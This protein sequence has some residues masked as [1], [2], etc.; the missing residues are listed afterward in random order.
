[1]TAPSLVL[2]NRWAVAMLFFAG[3]IQSGRHCSRLAWCGSASENKP[4]PD[5]L[6]RKR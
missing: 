3:F 1:M 6:A 5:R 4:K 2:E